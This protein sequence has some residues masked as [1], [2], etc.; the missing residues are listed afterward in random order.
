MPFI[1]HFYPLCGIPSELSALSITINS[2]LQVTN[3]QS[4]LSRKKLTIIIF[5]LITW[6]PPLLFV[7]LYYFFID[8]VNLKTCE[9]M[10]DN[11]IIFLGIPQ[12]VIEFLGCIICI[13]LLIIV[14]RLKTKNDEV[15][16]KSKRKIILKIFSFI[17]GIILFVVIKNIVFGNVLP[18]NVKLYS[19]SLFCLY[20]LLFEFIFVWNKQIKDNIYFIY[21]CKN[22]NAET[23]VI[24]D[25][26]AIKELMKY[27]ESN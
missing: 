4:L 18:H 9:I 21:C 27:S 26:Q 10:N 11:Y 16:K 25:T 24:S 14:C 12:I 20:F 8:D 19:H 5:I 6:I 3:N 17:L 13:I 1:L 2:Y 23:T 22:N 15:L 7:F